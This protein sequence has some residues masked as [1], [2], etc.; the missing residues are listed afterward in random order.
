MIQQLK[1]GWKSLAEVQLVMCKSGLR[2]SAPHGVGHLRQWSGEPE[3]GS[4]QGKN[5]PGS[6]D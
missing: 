2:A 6:L 4:N 3:L 1:I 5:S